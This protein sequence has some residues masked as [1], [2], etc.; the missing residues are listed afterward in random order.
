[1]KYRREIDGL[2]A[3]AVVSVIFF[4]AGFQ[5]FSGGYVGVDIFFVISGYL[6]TSII[7]T[8]QSA[9]AFSLANF[10]ERR[11]RRILPA[12][13]LVLT[14]C[15]PLAWL[16]L[17]PRDMDKFSQSLV[18]VS[19]FSSNILFWRSSGYFETVAELNPLLHTWSLAVEEQFYLLF[20]I[21]LVL[22]WRLGKRW[23]IGLLSLT[24]AISLVGASWGVVA[25]PD[26]TFF[27]LPTRGWEL[28]LGSFVA[29]YFERVNYQESTKTA[30]QVGSILGLLLISLAIF[31][32]DKNTP[33]PGLY[34]LIPTIGTALIILFATPQTIAGK[35]L[36]QKWIVGMG[37]ISYS[38][39][40]WHQ[41]LLAFSRHRDFS[42]S[43]Q[44]TALTIC[45]VTFILAYLSWRFV[46]M[47]FR[48]KKWL[49]RKTIFF[50][51]LTGSL[52]FISLGLIGQVMHGNVGQLNEQQ[53]SFLA[54][55]DNAL[56]D[57][58]YFEKIRYEEKFRVEC[59]FY[60]IA[61]YKAGRA[62]KTPR[63]SISNHCYQDSGK[64]KTLFIW[65][66]SHA[67]QLYW[68]LKQTM[69]DDWQILQVATSSCAPGIPDQGEKSEI[70][71][72]A[73]TFALKNIE[74]LKP[75]VI[76]IAQ[77]VGHNTAK[78]KI[79]SD[80]LIALGVGKVV[81]A[82]P[83]PHWKVDLPVVIAKRLMTNMPR[84]T[85]IG[86]DASA[87]AS[88]K[89]IKANFRTNSNIVYV[90]LID[91]F[92]NET[93]CKTYLGANAEE[94]IT[95]WDTGHITPLASYNLAKDILANIVSR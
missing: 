80:Y 53:K 4:H 92:C 70:C 33:F 39:Y 10:Y 64:P 59:D 3:I 17:M 72:K 28:L 90:S 44:F 31:L 94:G 49:S 86:L 69:P 12:L 42:K 91:Y 58:Q 74:A 54:Y 63:I 27:M 47:P 2:R 79:I 6:I 83:S 55:F 65:G 18:A 93:G 77:N 85:S 73:N 1:M 95:S 82:G 11:A 26:F 25:K 21:F 71:E 16:Y 84:Y 61:N 13:F 41:P 20:P 81:F 67:Q 51:S 22:S 23:L 62:T 7:I 50:L 32:Y 15:L 87:I 14:V 78:M 40:L 34:A 52:V 35:L 24:A 45:G 66:D 19:T 76:L 48:N 68:G 9:G 43:N 36:G 57:W 75:N 8:E 88:D 38:A 89:D 30:N 5:A 60:D 37:L 56:P 29:F 46:E